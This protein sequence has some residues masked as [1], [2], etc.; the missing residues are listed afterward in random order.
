MSDGS[1]VHWLRRPGFKPA[2]WNPI[3]ARNKKSGKIGWYCVH[4][5]EACRFCYAEAINRR[6]GTGVDYVASR[7]DEV[8]LFLDERVLRAP[9]HWRD[10]RMIFLDSMSDLYGEFVPDL[11]IARIAAV[12]ALCP[13]HIFIELTKRPDRMR[14][15]N[16]GVPGIAGRI[17]DIADLMAVAAREVAMRAAAFLR[18]VDEPWPLP[19]VWRGASVH[20][21]PSA[22][23]FVP[24][25]L[26]TPAA[27]RWISYEPALGPVDLAYIPYENGEHFN[28]LAGIVRNGARA[29]LDWV[30]A[31]GESGTDARGHDVGW[32]LA[33][34]RQCRDAGVA[35]Y[36]KQVGARPY[37]S[38]ADLA[39]DPGL[40]EWPRAREGAP[41]LCDAKKAA[42]GRS[43]RGIHYGGDGEGRYHITG[44]RDR[45]GG[46]P[47]EWPA[48]LR[49]R[50]WPSFAK[51]PAVAEALAGR[52]EGGPA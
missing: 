42:G 30:V 50:E 7:R 11:W 13:Q 49:V 15:F 5:T 16:I 24:E 22:D 2:S 38:D 9:L 37:F 19:N 17:R 40:A 26:A 32:D 51:A 3:K 39:R 33:L 28:A 29:R 8:E 6:L 14:E 27:V 34:Q 21:Q 44:L 46:D 12:E 25:V 23:E 47:E 45:Q 41:N 48:E 31:G 35:F 18:T 20:D 4:K 10:P 43:G 52:S 1:G 36:E